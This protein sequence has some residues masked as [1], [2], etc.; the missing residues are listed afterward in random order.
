MEKNKAAG[1]LTFDFVFVRQTEIK[2]S[3][4]L[5]PGESRGSWAFCWCVFSK[6]VTLAVLGF[7]ILL[8]LAWTEL[9]MSSW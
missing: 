6:A 9:D 5:K 4:I 2:S 7:L 8:W 3:S 1:Y